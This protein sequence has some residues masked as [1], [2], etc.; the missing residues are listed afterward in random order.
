MQKA[1]NMPDFHVLLALIYPQDDTP[2]APM[3]AGGLAFEY[4]R[5]KKKKEKIKKVKEYKIIFLLA[6]I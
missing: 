2:S 5:K 3:I 1:Q 6:K 4:P